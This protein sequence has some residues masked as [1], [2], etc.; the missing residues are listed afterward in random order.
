MACTDQE[1]NQI[2]LPS[3]PSLSILRF[4]PPSFFSRY[5][6]L[7]PNQLGPTFR[8][9]LKQSGSIFIKHGKTVR[10][11]KQS[12][13]RQIFR[14]PFTI[15]KLLYSTSGRVRLFVNV[16]T[17]NT[18]TYKSLPHPPSL[19]SLNVQDSFDINV[20]VI[21]TWVVCEHVSTNL[22]KVQPSE[23]DTKEFRPYRLS[24]LNV[25]F[26]LVKHHRQTSQYNSS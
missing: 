22:Y 3:S 13:W 25:R 19:S 4:A 26:R 8:F 20:C 24:K 9:L 21:R 23:N 17:K 2:T 18:L 7:Y 15:F 1:E 10:D 12:P 14:C 11:I 6:C 16:H 5:R